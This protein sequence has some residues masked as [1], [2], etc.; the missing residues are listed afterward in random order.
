MIPPRPQRAKK[1]GDQ[2][3][4]NCGASVCCLGSIR[5][6]IRYYQ[7]Q[8]GNWAL[9]PLAFSLLF[10]RSPLH[11]PLSHQEGKLGPAMNCPCPFTTRY[12]TVKVYFT[13]KPL[14]RF[15]ILLRSN[16]AWFPAGV[17]SQDMP[18][19]VPPRSPDHVK[20]RSADGSNVLFSNG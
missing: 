5:S 13:I 4:R 1:S 11:W 18:R 9:G 19:R 2:I 6:I 17:V 20:W 14:R 10:M 3:Q 16:P 12:E 7:V 15:P 8:K